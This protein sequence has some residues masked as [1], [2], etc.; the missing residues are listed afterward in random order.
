[1]QHPSPL[2]ILG[3]AA[4]GA[5]AV[6]SAVIPLEGTAQ[7]GAGWSV[8]TDTPAGLVPLDGGGYRVHVPHDICAID[9]TLIGGQ[10][11]AS[12][13]GLAGEAGGEL[14][15]TAQATAGQ[16]FDRY[17]GSAGGNWPTAPPPVRTASTPPAIRA[18]PTVV[19]EGAVAVAPVPPSDS[20]ARSSSVRAEA[21]VAGT[22]A[23]PAGPWTRGR[24]ATG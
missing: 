1:V 4:L 13:S 19:P 3:L 11:G 8:N 5:M 17:P 22:R 2:R 10:G 6:T 7:A 14:Q 9:W 15:V 16:V 21:T 20:R 24:A 18:R 23:V 12:S